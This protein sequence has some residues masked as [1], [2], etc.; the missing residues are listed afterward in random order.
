MRRTDSPAGRR[1]EPRRS[2]SSGRYNGH[3]EFEGFLMFTL[4][5]LTTLP[6]ESLKSQVLQMVVD[7]FSDL[8]SAPLS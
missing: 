5:H 4:T 2:R 3:A 1:H 8:S 7:Y 6:P